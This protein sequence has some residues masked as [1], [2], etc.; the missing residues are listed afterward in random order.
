MKI[1]QTYPPDYLGR[2]EI[3]ILDDR[4]I[5]VY[6]NLIH[7]YREEF[8]YSELKPK[9]VRGRSGESGWATIGGNLLGLAVVT[10]VI[11]LFLSITAIGTA[12]DL[13]RI[14]FGVEI[15]LIVL[16]L[17]AFTSRAVIKYDYA[18]FSTKDGG[19]AFTLKLTKQ[20]R[21]LCERMIAL[22]IDKARQADIAAEASDKV[23]IRQ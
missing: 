1:S 3:E 15:G 8:D 12:R 19:H 16:A 21:E 22:I 10:S 5:L 23:V 18:S 7:E 13:F 6:K 4:I 2:Q 9:I 11:F 14:V 20:D 17:F